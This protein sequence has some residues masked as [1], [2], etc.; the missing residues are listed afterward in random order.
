MSTVSPSSPTVAAKELSISVWQTCPHHA[1]LDWLIR[2]A[3]KD[4]LASCDIT[5]TATEYTETDE[6]VVENILP[7]HRT[8][9]VS[10]LSSNTS[11]SVRMVCMD[12]EGAR[13]VS[14]TVHFITGK[15]LRDYHGKYRNTD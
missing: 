13:H 10:H 2:L 12:G 5:H 15:R 9:T 4:T 1:V 14:N 7:L 8:I 6:T 3:E 11:Y